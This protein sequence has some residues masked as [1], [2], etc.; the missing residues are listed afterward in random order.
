MSS[1]VQ[2]RAA[3]RCRPPQERFRQHHERPHGRSVRREAAHTEGACRESAH[4]DATPSNHPSSD[5]PACSFLASLSITN[6]ALV[7]QSTIEFQPGLNVISGASGSGKSVLLQAL[8][9]VLGM[10]VDKDMIRDQDNMA[11]ML[12]NLCRIDCLA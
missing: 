10:P 6:F 11:G 8:G 1:C 7:A 5:P 4:Q 12:F 3:L 9:V 2:Y